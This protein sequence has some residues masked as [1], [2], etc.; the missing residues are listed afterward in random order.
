MSARIFFDSKSLELSRQLEATILAERRQELLW[1]ITH[2]RQ[3][4]ENR[5][6]ALSESETIVKELN[7]YTTS[8]EEILLLTEI[9]QRFE[10]FKMIA[11]TE[12]SIPIEKISALA[13]DLLRNVSA[14]AEVNK[15]QMA[16]TIKASKNLN[17]FIDLLTLILILFVALLIFIGSLMLVNKIIK[18]IIALKNATEKIGKGDLSVR[19]PNISNDELGMLCT[20]FNEMTENISSLQQGRLNF[21]ASVAHDLKNPL[22]VIGLAAHRVQKKIFNLPE[23]SKWTTCIIEQIADL[24]NLLNDLMDSLQIQIG[25]MKMHVTDLE[26]S[27]LIHSL[28]QIHNETITTHQIVFE[29]EGECRINGDAMRLRRV[30]SNLISNAVKYSP[31]GSTILL[32]VKTSGNNAVITI[33]D[34]GYG[35]SGENVTKLFQPFERLDRTK[36]MVGG[37]GL[38]LFSAKMI[39]EVHGGTINIYSNVEKGATVEITL[40]IITHKEIGKF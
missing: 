37:T 10:K 20:T 28:Q 29:K 2:E 24:E 11:E 30:F 19:I 6:V 21:I 13:N 4:L 12:S 14:F 22:V 18:P 5:D 26:L 27:S 25:K 7:N 39:V 33:S 40:P 15:K 1:K 3:H 32:K 38:G 35:I 17:T 23:L 16:E 31:S 34:E 8:Q 36:E 9:K